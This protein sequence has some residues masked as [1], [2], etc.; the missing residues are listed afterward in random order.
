M[1]W[2]VWNTIVAKPGAAS[3]LGMS[4]PAATPSGNVAKVGAAATGGL[5]SAD[6]GPKL[7]DDRVDWIPRISSKPETA[8]AFD[9]L[10][11]VTVMPRI[12]AGYVMGKTVRCYTQ[13]GTVANI[14]EAECRDW[15]ANPPFDPY[16]EVKM[17]QAAPTMLQ[18]EKPAAEAAPMPSAVII[19]APGRR[20]P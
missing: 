6:S 3:A 13:Q 7:I 12:A 14:S 9:Q 8:P 20:D 4:A 10:R 18:H 11:K 19:D 16:V 15:L 17:A 5:S 2:R 1:A